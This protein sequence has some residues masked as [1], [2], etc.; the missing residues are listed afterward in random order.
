MSTKSKKV[1]SADNR[2]ERLEWLVGWI[3]GFTDGEGCFSVGFIKQTDRKEKNR[4]RRG[5][6]TGYQP[7][8]EF[9]ITQGESSLKVLK[10]IR[11]YF[12]VGN[13]YINNRYDNHTENLYRYVVRKRD[14]LNK[15]IIPFFQENKLRTAK[16]KSFDKFVKCVDLITQ[17]EHLTEEGL[18]KIAKIA[19]HANRKKGG[20]NLSRILRDHTPNNK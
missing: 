5:Y 16:R 6:K 1:I 15:I 11:T 4:T 17:G 19:L 3:V 10:D 14:D 20:K 8:H 2:Q 12:G 9:A 7:F 18:V 13:I